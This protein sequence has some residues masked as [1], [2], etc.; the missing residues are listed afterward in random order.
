M[1]QAQ[2]KESIDLRLM[3]PPFAGNVTDEAGPG[4]ISPGDLASLR[5]KPP[6]EKSGD[7][8]KSYL[9]EG[10]GGFEFA[11][12]I[13]WRKTEGSWLGAWS[14]ATSNESQDPEK[15]ALSLW[16]MSTGVIQIMALK[17]DI[18]RHVRPVNENQIISYTYDLITQSLKKK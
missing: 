4:K 14:I 1:I 6:I 12:A 8:Y 11:V 2:T 15:T 18:L 17:I 5:Y 9:Q 16:G 7:N 3:V 13:A 10:W